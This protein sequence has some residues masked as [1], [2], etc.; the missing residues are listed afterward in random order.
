V[1][2]RRPVLDPLEDVT[3]H[4]VVCEDTG[5]ESREDVPPAVV[6]AWTVDG[7]LRVEHVAKRFGGVVA[8]RDVS[9]QL[10]AAIQSPCFAR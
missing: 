9:L 6:P 3:V 4:R 10:R 7:V 1:S 8:L 2:A 5:Y